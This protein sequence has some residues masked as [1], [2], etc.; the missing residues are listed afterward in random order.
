MAPT[1]ILSVCPPQ[2]HTDLPQ[3]PATSHDGGTVLCVCFF[4]VLIHLNVTFVSTPTLIFQPSWICNLTVNVV[5][6]WRDHHVECW[7]ASVLP[8]DTQ[9][10]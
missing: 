1:I 2:H 6:Q 8:P 9:E 3:S 10:L 7:L 4:Y 5:H